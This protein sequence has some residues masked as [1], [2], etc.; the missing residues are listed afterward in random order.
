MLSPEIVHR[1]RDLLIVHKPA[2]MPTTSPSH[3]EDCLVRWVTEHVGVMRAH[4]T[5]RLDSPV[6]GLVTFA[7][8]KEANQRLLEARRAGTYERL[9]LGVTL[10]HLG[11]ERGVW[12]WP[13]SVDPRNAK[14]RMAGSGRGERIARTRYAI[15]AR[16]PRAALLRLMPET[17]RTHQLRVHSAKAGAPLFGDHAYGGER[18]LSLPDGTVV[19]ARRVMLHC[20]KVAFPWGT[21]SLRLKAIPPDDMRR[22]WVAL[23]GQ[24]TDFA[25]R[26]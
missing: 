4:P 3:D 2:G 10:H 22:A 9:Y 25:T 11:D 6:S 23:G 26:D 16:T 12:S 20:A 5:S 18:R 7:L 24:E 8:S 15:A 1:D 17:G 14:L 19:T 13:I 21:G